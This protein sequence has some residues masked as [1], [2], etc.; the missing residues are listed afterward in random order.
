MSKYRMND[1]DAALGRSRVL[2]CSAGPMSL[3]QDDRRVLASEVARLRS[4]INGLSRT[5]ESAK[6]DIEACDGVDPGT[7]ACRLLNALRDITVAVDAA[8]E[9]G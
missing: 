6:Y 9:N 7:P 5:T 4:T 2:D 1:V 8:L 3:A